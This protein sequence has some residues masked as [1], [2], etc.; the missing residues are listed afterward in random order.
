MKMEKLNPK[1]FKLRAEIITPI[2][3]DNWEVYDRL[4]YFVF[5]GRDVIQ[6]VD[7]K[8][9]IDCANLDKNLFNKII[10][11]IEE[12]NF[13]KLESL[14][15]EFYDKYFEVDKYLIKETFIWKQALNHLVLEWNKNNIWEIKRFISSKFWDLI[16]PW[17]TLKWLFKTMFLFNKLWELNKKYYKE[18][19]DELEQISKSDKV[20]NIFS[21]IE[22]EDVKLNNFKLKISKVLSYNKPKKKWNKAL[23]WITQVLELLVKWT[24]EIEIKDLNWVFSKEKIENMVKNYSTD[25][26]AREEQ[27]VENI[28]WWLNTNIIEMLDEHMSKWKYP[29]KI[30]MFKKS[31]AY[32][33]FWEEMIENLNKI[34]WKE[35]LTKSKKLWVGDKTLYTDENQ[36][37]IWWIS[38]E[39][40]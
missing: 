12:G 36:N 30:W 34:Q 38:L 35:W 22:F 1:S 37:P 24:F 31:L 21:F 4:D 40:V 17:S 27:I 10:K 9:L 13:N 20:K 5:D 19:A 7:R 6:I 14:K 32:K 11:S 29:V 8:W 16:I 2:H 18:Q 39:V 3:I 33:I 15:V 26:I 23:R 25:I 28:K